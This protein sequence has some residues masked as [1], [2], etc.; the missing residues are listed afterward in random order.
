LLSLALTAL[1]LNRESSSWSFYYNFDQYFY[2]EPQDKTQGVGLFGR[3]GISDGEANAVETF[4]SIGVGGMGLIPDRDRDKFG[5]GYFFTQYADGPSDL[6]GLAD[7]QGVELFYN[8]EVA[9][10][11]HLTPD[12]QVIMNPG[13]DSDRDV[14]IVYGLRG[15]VSF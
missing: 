7:S 4:Y 11:F 13:G 3:F 6:L 1:N 8:I 14:A 5:L 2:V 12:L 15:Q 9:P 10:W